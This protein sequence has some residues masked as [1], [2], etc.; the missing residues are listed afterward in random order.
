[1]PTNDAILLKETA[2]TTAK[3]TVNYSEQ[4]RYAVISSVHVT[5][6]GI[7]SVKYQPDKFTLWLSRVHT[8]SRNNVATI[9]RSVAFLHVATLFVFQYAICV[10]NGVSI[11]IENSDVPAHLTEYIP[12][13]VILVPIIIIGILTH[14]KTVWSSVALCIVSVIVA[15]LL[16][17]ASLTSFQNID[18]ILETPRFKL[19]QLP[20]LERRIAYIQTFLEA[21]NLNTATITAIAER[22]STF[23]ETGEQLAVELARLVQLAAEKARLEELAEWNYKKTALALWA[24]AACFCAKFNVLGGLCHIFCGL[25]LEDMR[26][27][28]EGYFTEQRIEHERPWRINFSYYGLEALARDLPDVALYYGPHIAGH[29][30]V[31]IAG[32][33]L[34]EMLGEMI[35]ERIVDFFWGR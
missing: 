5:P 1:M 4:E 33:L 11:R 8:W 28:T 2:T 21:C 17:S 16:S 32:Q 24:T 3:T 27:L 23:K 7:I 25:E 20:S 19:H 6:D 34:G 18:V 30:A 26:N 9:H 10:C 12:C 22:A 15:L 14:F 13:A 31:G 29:F 35:G